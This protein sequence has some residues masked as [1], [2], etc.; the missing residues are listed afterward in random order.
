MSVNWTGGNR[1]LVAGLGNLLMRDDGV[2]VHAAK[3]LAVDPPAGASVVDVGTAVWHLPELLKGVGLLLAIDAM[4][5][6]GTPGS[7]YL[8]AVGD[9]PARTRP[10]SAHSM[11]L[12]EL[13]RGLPP[14]ERPRRTIALG[15]EPDEVDYGMQLSRAV[16]AALP[17]VIEEARRV[18]A[19]WRAEESAG[20]SRRSA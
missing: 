15:V 2:G 11:G 9:V 1:I 6:G 5:A 16:Q 20:S 14:E 13:L 17:R 3:I 19:R 12:P 10:F 8:A 18:V 4:S 7:V